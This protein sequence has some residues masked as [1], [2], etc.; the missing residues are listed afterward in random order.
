MLKS[1]TDVG[2]NVTLDQTVVC[3]VIKNWNPSAIKEAY[4]TASLCWW[5]LSNQV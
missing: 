5:I 3:L 2:F 1:S 4:L